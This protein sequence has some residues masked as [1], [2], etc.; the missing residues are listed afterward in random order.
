MPSKC[1]LPVCAA[2]E[3]HADGEQA[4]F[5]ALEG[6]LQL[7][8]D[9]VNSRGQQGGWAVAAAG[10]NGLADALLR[11]QVSALQHCEIADCNRQQGLVPWQR[12]L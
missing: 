10:C 5:V 12:L 8:A 1:A 3:P 11:M 4:G 7:Y 6:S 9:L 2:G